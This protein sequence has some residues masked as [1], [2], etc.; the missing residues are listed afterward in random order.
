[1]K[2]PSQIVI[3][4][5]STA[6]LFLFAG[7]AISKNHHGLKFDLIASDRAKVVNVNVI[8]KGSTIKIK[9]KLRNKRTGRNVQIPGYVEIS[10]IAADGSIISTKNTLIRKIKSLAAHRRNTNS[11]YASFQ[12]EF[13][14]VPEPGSVI[15][16][17]HLK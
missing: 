11:R 13:K 1:M 9:G 10:I 12:Y 16:I 17:K 3:M 2:K 8:E 15:R 14:K 5:C 4:L 7:N 6:V